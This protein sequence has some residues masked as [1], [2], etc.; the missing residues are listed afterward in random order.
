MKVMVPVSV[1]E[2]I[3]KIT[4]LNLKLIKV[5]DPDKLMMVRL[6]REML[7]K[8]FLKLPATSSPIEDDLVT[9]LAII[10]S[11]LWDVEDKL[12][13]CERSGIFSN[14]AS[15]VDDFIQ[16]ARSVYHLNDQRS[17]LKNQINQVYGSHITEVKS[18]AKY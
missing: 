7:L 9:K 5:T 17:D 15:G 12:R 13:E 6:E 4:I 18:Y 1:G 8:V 2:L 14:T 3:D 16:L 11:Q 10:N